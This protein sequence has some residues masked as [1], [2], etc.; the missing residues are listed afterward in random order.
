MSPSGQG[1]TKLTVIKSAPHC[2][3]YRSNTGCGR[4]SHSG[5]THPSGCV[6]GRPV[7][8]RTADLSA[9]APTSRLGPETAPER[10]T[11]SDQRQHAPDILSAN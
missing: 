6:R 8:P 1:S 4:T 11:G 9:T 2:L 5:H 3:Q 10:S 7:V